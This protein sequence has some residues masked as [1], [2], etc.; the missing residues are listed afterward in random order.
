MEQKNR[1][2]LAL[3]TFFLVTVYTAQPAWAWETA[4]VDDGPVLGPSSLTVDGSDHVHIVYRDESSQGLKYATNGTGAWVSSSIEPS[5]VV[6]NPSVAV[7]DANNLHIVCD[8]FEGQIKYMT[9]SSGSWAIVDIGEIGLGSDPSIAIGPSGHV[10]LC[11]LSHSVIY[12]TNRSGDWTSEQITHGF[13][14]WEF[15]YGRT[16]IAVDS[17]G[18]VHL[19]YGTIE[20]LPGSGAEY[21]ATNSSGSWEETPLITWPFGGI[22]AWHPSLAID[23]SDYV[24]IAYVTLFIIGEQFWNFVTHASDTTGRMRPAMVAWQGSELIPPWTAMATDS[25]NRAHIAYGVRDE[26]DSIRVNYATNAHGAW[27][28]SG[29]LSDR[30]EPGSS[31]PSM[32]VDSSGNVHIS[33]IDMDKRLLVTSGVGEDLSP[34]WP[35]TPAEASGY[36]KTSREGSRLFNS[37]AFLLVPIGTVILLSVLR[38]SR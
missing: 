22:I 10:H 26:D 20:K 3:I 1:W 37:L 6:D 33:Y 4:V 15:L 16:D 5:L 38:R 21:Y 17:G 36:E 11:F 29:P 18:Y 35:G 19:R 2:I 34:T 27:T 31:P 24:H 32:G 30:L 12:T 14:V 25:A 9:N 7:D 23:A 13:D 28:L 8:T